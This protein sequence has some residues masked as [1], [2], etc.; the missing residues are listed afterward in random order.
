MCSNPLYNSTERWDQT[1]ACKSSYIW[2]PLSV[3]SWTHPTLEWISMCLNALCNSTER[4][5]LRSAC[6]GAYGSHCWSIHDPTPPTPP[7]IEHLCVQTHFTIQL[8]GEI[9]RQHKA[10]TCMTAAI[11]PFM[12]SPHPWM[13]IYV[14][15][16]TLQFNWEVRFEVSM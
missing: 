1:L 9:G 6:K 16:H 14:F 13:N 11:N 10:P 8:R 12:N 2:Q 4:W 3:H 5:D 15:K 7:M